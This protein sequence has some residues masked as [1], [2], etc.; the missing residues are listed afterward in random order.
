MELFGVKWDIMTFCSYFSQEEYM[1]SNY[2]R[3]GKNISPDKRL[4]FHGTTSYDAVRGISIN[5]FDIRVSGTHGT[6][7]GD[8]AYFARDAKYSHNYTQPPNRLMFLASVL[9]G[10]FTEGNKTYR[11]PPEIPGSQYELYDSCVNDVVDPKIFVVFDKNQFYPDYLIHYQDLTDNVKSSTHPL[12]SQT[13]QNRTR[14]S[15]SL[16]DPTS[17]V[18]QTVRPTSSTGKS[19]YSSSGLMLQKLILG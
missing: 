9:V 5:N 14:I 11:R 12:A 1:Q 18:H 16:S 8:G 10:Q 3:V 13:A 2:Q 19:V 17:T 4:L 7:Y 15:S 6:M